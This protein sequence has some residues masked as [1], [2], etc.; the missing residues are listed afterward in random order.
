MG[1]FCFLKTNKGVQRIVIASRIPPRHFEAS[2]LRGLGASSFR[3]RLVFESIQS[4]W[5][6]IWVTL[7]LLWAYFG[8]RIAVPGHF[9]VTLMSLWDQFGHGR[10][11]G[12]A[13]KRKC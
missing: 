5:G 8:Y 7:G 4:I 11:F 10:V 9:L 6:H 13:G 12:K 3:K 2:R 1:K